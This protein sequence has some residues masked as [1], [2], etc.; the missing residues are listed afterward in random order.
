MS[1]VKNLRAFGAVVALL[2][3]SSSFA[4][5]YTSNGTGGGAFG[6]AATWSPQ[7]V[8]GGGDTV[9]ITASDTVTLSGPQTVAYVQ[10]DS[11]P[12]TKKLSVPLGTSLTVAGA[13]T[14][15][16]IDVS[17]GTSSLELDGGFAFVAGDVSIHGEA[18]GTGELTFGGSGGTI[19]IAGDINFVGTTTANAVVGFVSSAGTVII[20]G[21][22][23]SGGTLGGGTFKFDGA[24]SQTIG[25][26]YTFGSLIINKSGTATLAVPTTVEYLLDIV[27]GILDDG[28]Q[29]ISL[30]AGAGTYVNID[31]NGVLKLGDATTATTFPS[32]VLLANVTF[33]ANSAVV[34]HAGVSQSV[35]TAVT[36]RRLYVQSVSGGVTHNITGSVLKVVE[37]L[38]I[39]DN[40][41]NAVGL[42]INSSL[43]DLDGDLAGDGT[44]YV[45]NSGAINI[46]GTWTS[47]VAFSYTGA[48][49]VTYDGTGAQSVLATTYHDLVINKPSGTATLGGATT[50][51]NDLTVVAG[52]FDIGVST[53]TLHGDFTNT[54]TVSASTATIRLNGSA[55]QTFSS[56]SAVILS[57]LEINNAA[58]VSVGNSGITINGS[59]ILNGGKVTVSGSFF[60]DVL[61]SIT[62]YSGWVIGELTIGMNATPA[63]TFHVGTAN[64]YLPVDVDAGSAGTIILAAVEAQHPSATGINVLTRYWTIGAPSTVT[65][66]DSITFHYNAADVTNGDDTKFILGRHDG[67]AWTRYGDVNEAA[68][69]ATAT[70]VN[71]F[72]GGWVIGQRGSLGGA[73]KLAITSINSGSNPSEDTPF[74]VT[75]EAQNDNGVATPVDSATGVQ[76]VL[77]QGSGTL[78]GTTSA[79]IGAAAT[80]TTLSGVSYDTIENNVVLRANA[81]AGDPLD[82]GDSSTFNVTAP[83]STVTVS[84]INDNGA[85]TLREAITTANNGGCSSPCMIEF[86]TAGTIVLQSP[87]PAITADNLTINGFSAPGSSANTNS[88]GQPSNAVLT[89]ALDGINGIS[90]GLDV[91]TTFVQIRGLAVMNFYAGG[92]GVGIR[93][94]G[95]N[96]GSNI[97]G[98]YIGTDLTGMIAA[99]NGTGILFDSS[100]E[101]SVGGTSPGMRNL[102]SGHSGTGIGISIAGSSNTISLYGNYVGVKADLTGAIPNNI[103]ISVGAGT[104]SVAIGT[105]G[106][107]NIVSGN[108]DTGIVLAGNG[109]TLVSNL[110]GTAGDTATAMANLKGIVIASTGANNTIGGVSPSHINTISGNTTGIVIAGNN[111][112]VDQNRIGVA[113]ANTTP[114]GNTGT[115]LLLTGTAAGN[116]I[117]S[118]FGN[119][120]AHNTTGVATGSTHTGLGNT[121]RRNKIFSNSTGID[122]ASDG[123]TANDGTDTDTGSNNLQNFPVVSEARYSSG[124]VTLK[125]SL[126]SSG[127]VATNFFEFDVY[128]GDPSVL[129]QA[130]E[131]IGNSGCVAGNVFTNFAFGVAA[132]SLTAGDKIVTTATA[133]NDAACNTPTEGT[134]ELSSAAVIGGEIHWIGG[135]GNWDTSSN[136]SPAVVP[137]SADDVIID[138][139]GTYTVSV[140]ANV[141][142]NSISVG[143]A[144]GADVQT[145]DVVAGNSLTINAASSVNATGVLALNGSA[146]SGPGA[147]DVFGT[148]NWNAGD[149]NGFTPLDI[150]N[151]GTLNINTAT[152]KQLSQRLLTV[153]AGGTANW[154]DGALQLFNAAGIDNYG[155]FEAKANAAMSDAGSDAGFDNFGTFR[156]ST[157]TGTMTFSGV[158]FN[159]MG[160]TA[161]VESGVLD[162]G[163]GS[164][165]A[166]FT[167]DNGAEILINSDSYLLANGTTV[168]GLGSLR[169]TTGGTLNVGG[170]SVPV[171][172][173]KLEGGSIV[174]SGQLAT[175]TNGAFTWTG[176]TMSGAGTTYIDSF[177]TL[178][179]SGATDKHLQRTLSINGTGTVNFG[180]AGA[181]RMASGGN[182]VNLGTFEL[183]DA[184]TFLNNGAAG[185]F[186]N[187]GT[188]RSTS[189]GT[190]IFNGIAVTNSATLDIDQGVFDAAAIT[191]SGAIIND[192]TLYIDGDTVTF[193]AGTNVSG[194]G[195]VHVNG[196]TLTINP[197]ISIPYLQLDAGTISG[198][199]VIT[200]QDMNWTG[201][202]MSGSGTT[203]IGGGFDLAISGTSTKL[204]NGRTLR[205]DP[206]G[207]VTFG[208]SGALNLQSGANVDNVGTFEIT[209][210]GGV[211]NA[212][213]AGTFTNSGL[214][215]KS[216]DAGSTIFNGQA[217]DNTGTIQVDLGIL[218][219][220]TVDSSG[221]I[222]LTGQLQVNSDVVKLTGGTVAGTGNILVNGGTLKV[223]ANVSIPSL[224]LNSGNINGTGVLTLSDDAFWNG[225]SMDTAGATAVGNGAT[226]T[227]GG[228][229]FKNL[230]ARGLT[231]N[232]GG[233]VDVTGNGFIYMQSGASITNNGTWDFSADA[234][235]V[236]NG[237]AAGFTNNN[238]VTKTDTYG[239]VNVS[240][241]FSNGGMVDL[242]TGTLS[243]NS[244]TQTAAG[245][246]KLHL[247]GT[248]AGSQ[249]SQLLTGTNPALAGTLQLALV[250]FYEPVGGNTFRAVSI[251]GGSASGNFATYTYPPLSGGRSFSSALDANGLLLTVA[252]SA[253]L[254]ITKTAPANVAVGD[255][256]TY[257]LTVTNGSTEAATSV[258]V[259]DTLPAGHTSITASGTGWTCSVAGSTVTCTADSSLPSGTANAITITA[260]APNTAQTITNTATVSSSNDPNSANNS[261]SVTVVVDNAAVDL[262]LGGTSPA[263]PVANGT[264]VTFTFSVTNDGP[265]PATGVIFAADIPAAV[266]FNS[267][268]IGASNCTLSNRTLTCPGVVLNAS[269][270]V[271]AVISVAANGVGTQIVKASVTANETETDAADNQMSQSVGVSGSS[272]TVTNTS[273]SGSGSLRQ[274]LL[275]ALFGPCVA[276]CTIAFNLG[277]GPY[278]IQPL[279]DLPDVASSTIVDA[280]TQPGYTNMPIVEIDAGLI[281]ASYATFIV[282][283]DVTIRGFSLTNGNYGI[284]LNGD[285]NIVEAN[286]IGLTPA[287]IA[288]ANQ[289]GIRVSGDGNMIG[290]TLPAQRNIVSGNAGAGILLDGT[291]SGTTI[292]GNYVGTDPGGTLARPN[293]A[294]IDILGD[295]SGTTIGGATPAHRNLISG[296][297]SYGIY[298][299]GAATSAA[300]TVISNNWIGP[301]VNGTAAFSV[302]AGVGL[303]GN[304]SDTVISNNVISGVFNGIRTVQSTVTGTKIRNNMIGVRPDGTTPMGNSQNGIT[305]SDP[306]N[307]EIGGITGEGNIIGNNGGA[308]VIITGANALGNKVLGNSIFNNGG[309]GIDLGATGV[310]PNDAGDG[311]VGPNQL[312]NFPVISSAQLAAGNL[313]VAF[314]LDSGATSTLVEIFKADSIAGAEGMTFLAR[315]C[316]T[317]GALN[318]TITAPGAPVSNGHGIVATATT[319]SDGACNTPMAGT[320]EFSAA[321]TVAA[322]TPPAA[323][324]TAPA[325]VC[326]SSTGNAASVNAPAATSFTW[327]ISGGT[328]ATGQGTSA[329]TFNAGATG[330]VALTVTVTDGSG[331][332]NT[333][334]VT[335]PINPAP[336]ISI[337]GPPTACGSA[338]LT[339]SGGFT[340]YAWSHGPTT[341]SIS[342]T[343]SGTY[344]VTGTDASG[345][346]A[347]TSHNITITSGTPA[348]ITASGPTTFCA[349]GSVV[350][351]ANNGTTYAWSNGANT[352]SITV[353]ATGTFTVAVTDGSGCTATSAPTSVTVNPVPTPSI[354]PSGPTTFCSGGSV[355]LTASPASSYLWS[356]NET[357]QSITV[358]TSGSYSV[359]V[360]NNGCT[361]TSAPTSVSVTS[362][363]TP[364]ITPSGPTTFCNGGSVTLTSSPAASY[365]WSNGAT[366]QSIT[367]NASGTF[368][369]TVTNGSGC[370]ATSAPTSV[371][372]NSG[373]VPTIT[374]SGPTAFCDGGSIT[375]T[376]S[377]AASYA[378]SNGA[379]T[380]SI[381]VSASGTFTVTTVDGGGCSATSAP[382]TVTEHPP[383]TVAITPSYNACGSGTLDAGPG[384]VSYL[385]STGETTQVINI[386]NQPSYSVTVTDANG[387]TASDAETINIPPVVAPSITASGPTTFC[388][389]GS[390]TLTAN[391]SGDS[392]LWSNGATT[393]SITV[394][395]SGTFTVAIT[396]SCGTS[397]A[398]PKSVTVKPAPSAVINAPSSADENTANLHASVAAQAGATYA[399]SMLNGTITAG[400]GTNDITFTAGNAGTTKVMVTV[401]LDGCSA[402]GTRNVTVNG[403]VT[404]SAD[405]ALVKT[406]PSSVQSG[407]S[408]TYTLTASNAGPNA[409][410]VVISDTLPAGTTLASMSGGAFQC[411]AL[412]SGVFCSG[413]LAVGASNVLTLTVTAPRQ[414]GTITNTAT[415][416]GSVTDPQPDNNTSSAVTI[417]NGSQS[418]C[419]TTP[420]A[421]TAPAAGASVGSPVTF[422]WSA[423]EGAV[424]Y[425]LWIDQSLAGVTNALSF[426]KPL[427]SGVHEWYVVARFATECTPLVSATRTFTVTAS[428]NCGTTAPALTAPNGG[429]TNSPVTFA[430]TPVPQAIGYRVWIEVNG[431]AAQE[432]GTTDGAISLTT[433]VPSGAIV[434]HVDALF[435][436]C[437]S[438]RSAP[439]AFTVATPDPC[440][441]RG[442]A[443]TLLPANNAT[444]NSSSLDLQWSAANNADGY[445][446]WASI[447]GG[448]PS[449]LGETT[450]ELSLRVNIGH[451]RVEWWITA[452]YEGC[453]STESQHAVFTI[454]RR[455][456]CAG[457][458][459]NA[460]SPSGIALTNAQVTFNWTQVPQAVSYEVWLSVESGTPTLIGTTTATSL[461]EVVAPGRLSWYVVAI[462]GGCP[463][464]QSQTASFTYTPPANCTT[465]VRAAAVAPLPNAEVGSPVSFAWTAPAGATR[466]ELFTIRGGN[467]TLTATT[468][469]NAAANVTLAAGKLRWFVRTHFGA[470]CAPLDSPEQKLD[471]VTPPAA[472]SE[473]TAPQIAAVGQISSGVPFLIQWQEIPGATGYQL[474]LASTAS[475]ADAEMVSTDGAQHALNRANDGAS[476]VAV[477]ARVR[478]I[479][480]RCT[481]APTATPFGPA[482]AIFILPAIGNEVAAPL[483]G[484]IVSQQLLLGPELAGQSFVASVKEPWLSVSPSSGVVAA[485]G[486]SLIVTANT[487]DLPL[488]TSLGAVRITLTS[489]ARGVSAHASTLNVS[490]ISVGKV[491]PV[492]PTPKTAPPPD[493]L[494][495]PAVAHADGINSKFQSDVRVTNSSA[496]LLNYQVS[497]I[498]TGGAGITSGKQTQF[499]IE[500]GRTIAL[501]DVLKS[502][503]GTG[504]AS[505]TGTLEV[506]PLTQTATSTSSNALSG[507]PNLVTFASSR[508]FN[509]TANGTFGQYIPA[510]PFANFIGKGIDSAKPAVLSLQQIAQSDR[511]RTNLGIVEGSGEAVSLLVKVF[512]NNG[513]KLTEFPVNLAGGQHTQLN[514]FLVAQ[515]VGP[516]SDGR[517]EVS[518]VGGNGKVTA[519]A[520]VLDNDTS[521]PLLVTPVTLSDSGSN[522]WV[523]P[524]VADLNNGTA[525]WQTDMRVFNAGTT[526]AQTTLTFYSQN[527]GTPKTAQVT[528]PAGQV[529]QFDRTLA[530]V[531]GAS[532]DGGAVHITTPGSARLIAT[533]RTY[534]QTSTGTYG[535]FISAVTT[536]EAAGVGSRPLQ[537]LQVEESDRFRSNIGLA[538]VTGNPVKLELSIIPPDAKFTVVTEVTLQAN[539]FRQLNALLRSAGLGETYNARVTVR[540]VEGN[541]RVTAYA[542]VIDMQTNDPTY[543]PAQ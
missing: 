192:G 245:T 400:Q 49:T 52:T 439:V 53:L 385:W 344:T 111:N 91:Q 414:S 231:V 229:S 150:E 311:D 312:Q 11:T 232:A 324:I 250:G 202:T 270:S 113:P 252:G 34:Y 185:I 33:A 326:A 466:Y 209:G 519:Y 135:S 236:D 511:Y 450:D 331:C 437:P 273:D 391:P 417:V 319:Y 287:G 108:S 148:L 416:D 528:I 298:I 2:I 1:R 239:V 175:G 333:A 5:T 90:T 332:S 152:V 286:Y 395:A 284:T 517:I 56:N 335:F 373:T 3:A 159:Q 355:T 155:L 120:I 188:L 342:V 8:P 187:G 42:Q 68:R 64:A 162:L 313:T 275:D 271:N 484:G 234:P 75:V 54:G 198:P 201:G 137:T 116:T 106:I 524:G 242:Q 13:G 483:T 531:F 496:Q 315:Q 263:G 254:S 96:S 527:G 81:T 235:L 57:S 204:L 442:T 390:V 70:A 445:R 454:P 410:S 356:T 340:S 145:L 102:V 14:S 151:G 233:T 22:L 35:N 365:A 449:V 146:L 178:T 505:V 443:A 104:S 147:L 463:S 415:I 367:V 46:G 481:P 60:V 118:I 182:I 131:W 304:V 133:Y 83:P 300:N 351:T 514:S 361:A 309:I 40:G 467:T 160:G 423:V 422:S 197:N 310:T 329:I 51:A 305:L 426:T 525:N 314:T 89:V 71:V 266:T 215:R 412:P 429:T 262:W 347:T 227:I 92:A 394:T 211:T 504:G 453:A 65:S 350:L 173:L 363:A 277:A 357:T 282:H 513:A 399:W 486:T 320:S 87:L 499:S 334:S 278:K 405:V 44:L 167:I 322:C 55:A 281:N 88:F 25:G 21:D 509:V 492:M 306:L 214:L 303:F 352:Q 249:Y 259:T 225:G 208:G 253:D 447:D 380:Q 186:N 518:V 283:D 223:D 323:T 316:Y 378:W 327:T 533:A 194:G 203:T 354:T 280:T 407:A 67:T 23:G 487:T 348:T 177:G 76:L 154:N 477:Y 129:T 398:G 195:F 465:N 308:G 480:A 491:S 19:D 455:N 532:N 508:T 542:S 114:L 420:P 218:D 4:A 424:E 16:D 128:K 336:A 256:I 117:G 119:T 246:L 272:M 404:E 530:S 425:E 238:T 139:A 535:Q 127:G 179:L 241:P 534:N 207:N 171:E 337:A 77:Q 470:G 375:L 17:M 328:I 543:V 474:Q 181:L 125:L 176:G 432:A 269:Q 418:N 174:G 86:S 460:Q 522:R 180:G 74:N 489:S 140:N 268:T 184:V 15:V 299:A 43:L 500:P 427:S 393:R 115:G 94:T 317:G 461:S 529:Q 292:S 199:S 294:G 32:P 230:S 130:A 343:A 441:N 7:G 431:T 82:F 243:V 169:V 216:T 421:L 538:E 29:Q 28:G 6:V 296:N 346:T 72:A 501:D 9:I 444:V 251:A 379:T 168:S 537:L 369:V 247:G 512:G 206:L 478:A 265:Q 221:T 38:N 226:L 291:P 142:A 109:A 428:N 276:P 490:T 383:T 472:C 392:Y 58:G 469:T 436:G 237:A 297:S 387:C 279:T 156:R 264:A 158:N 80:S 157:G 24:G 384:F 366:T 353:T 149:I 193:N 144:S 302:L 31:S 126:N 325:S 471:V 506:R 411:S 301:D 248:T 274:A 255:A 457:P 473:L 164:A 244:W 141:S 260:N 502:W 267:A 539:E 112:T 36:Y 377:A 93:M 389:G 386:G 10:F 79:T 124:T 401:T 541:G 402:N 339:A 359:Q 482:A 468:T 396:S 462:V 433:A 507:L 434:A 27:N 132:G 84:S 289:R 85:G 397:N 98:C 240:V 100:A 345:C 446:V 475:F 97:N 191:N 183:D 293:A 18:S 257:T 258:S 20:G 123:V 61:A 438:T 45:G 476:P 523:M 37:S 419:S 122:L 210:Q 290:G 189:L 39:L 48:S 451:G 200:V 217:I 153:A 172:R 456:D 374:A 493:A 409:T 458:A 228:T 12:G 459:P 368:S 26:P 338:T 494:I 388:A 479:D 364:T 134:S 495:I 41:L 170:S 219:L 526:D 488:G 143:F 349:G 362:A 105:S 47:T 295:A 440:A 381:T 99:P 222:Q 30:D 220:A 165:Q 59:L 510:I 161:D 50:V 190:T 520:S 136:W 370:T 261:G 371:N 464:R 318:T 163:A 212:G 288:A 376:S 515:G 107:G 213:G 360:T 435:S 452:L 205:V 285:N 341:A 408:L 138:A 196:G 503:F 69:Q 321:A 224:T 521:D 307:A 166:A 62:R 485:G 121:F 403:T 516:V 110:I 358:T 66:L 63:R 103:G 101:A 540:A 430:W 406:A 372:A 497:F 73:G 498:P 95:D 330:S 536:N 413:T 382:L 78:S 448:T